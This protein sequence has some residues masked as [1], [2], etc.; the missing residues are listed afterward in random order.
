[1]SAQPIGPE[2]S[3]PT[4]SELGTAKYGS[5]SSL[6]T[7]DVAQVYSQRHDL[8]SEQPELA[9]KMREKLIDWRKELSAKMPTPNDPKSTGGN[10]R[11][12]AKDSG[13]D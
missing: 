6:G 11:K 1:M 8:A 12:R 7:S 2:T 9:K 13:D 4:N 10:K 5:T 3:M